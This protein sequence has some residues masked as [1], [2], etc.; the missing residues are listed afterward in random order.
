MAFI[1]RP[2]RKIVEMLGLINKSVKKT[3]KMRKKNYIK[4]CNQL[5]LIYKKYI[6]MCN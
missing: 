5:Q 6:K 3:Y 1:Y 2:F 4:I